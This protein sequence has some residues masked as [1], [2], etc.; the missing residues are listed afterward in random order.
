[1]RR[2]LVA[3]I[4]SLVLTSAGPH[5]QAPS[6]G[7]GGDTPTGD[8]TPAAWFVQLASPPLIEG[9]AAETLE[10]E[11]ARFHL[12]AAG[13]G[14][15]YRETGHYR[16]LWN[17][18][19]I[20]TAATDDSL[21]KVPG[22]VAVFPVIPARRAQQEQTPLD[23]ADM[24]TALHAGGADVAQDDFGLSGRGIRVAVLD[25]GIDYDHPDL[26]GCFGKD[27]R[28]AMGWDFVGDAFNPDRTSPTYNPLPVPDADP[29]D[30]DGH[31]THVAGII[32]ANGTIRGVAPQVTLHAYRVFG[33]VGPTT[34]DVILAAMERAY[35]D[36]A[37]V[38]N[39][40]LGAPFQ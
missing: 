10:A 40:S 17:G 33:C 4:V 26:G 30:C 36:G 15:E 9:S 27:C 14:I 11:E 21:I 34:T 2:F 37:D 6:P 18:L 25:S 19:T 13:V 22:V 38:L 31:G 16:H 23:V 24:I 5:G 3:A 7:T 20:E 1:M 32:G 8:E 12:A 35:Q 39:M 29:D 28:V